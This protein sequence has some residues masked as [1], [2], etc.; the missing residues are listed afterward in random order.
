MELIQ[1]LKSETPKWFKKIMYGCITL[2]GTCTALKLGL[3][4]ASVVLSP[5]ADKLIQYGIVAGIVGSIVAKTACQ[6]PPEPKKK[7]AA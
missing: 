5:L 3:E 7:K 6:T 4:E 2:G 1:R